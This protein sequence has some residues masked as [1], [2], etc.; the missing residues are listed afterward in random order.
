MFH[1]FSNVNNP[2]Q[3]NNIANCISLWLKM[4]LQPAL[5]SVFF[6]ISIK[7]PLVLL[8]SLKTGLSKKLIKNFV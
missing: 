1:I 3:L 5:S 4:T 7:E 6:L 2:N 8:L